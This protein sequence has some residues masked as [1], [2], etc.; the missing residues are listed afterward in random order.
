MLYKNAAEILQAI[1]IKNP[2]QKQNFYTDKALSG[3]VSRYFDGKTWIQICDIMIEP[4]IENLIRM[5]LST[6]K[7][8]DLYGRSNSFVRDYTERRWD[9]IFSNAQVYFKNNYLG[10]HEYD[11]FIDV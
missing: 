6:R 10:Y 4:I 3:L 5:G 9:L 7:I 8:G 11:N 2:N 1:G